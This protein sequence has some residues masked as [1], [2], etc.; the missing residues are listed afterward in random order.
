MI[1]VVEDYL[2][3]LLENK[4][5]YLRKNPDQYRKVLGSSD[6]RVNRLVE[7][8]DKNSI[9][10]IKGYPR[11]P[12]QLPC[13][14]ILLSGEEENQEALGNTDEYFEDRGVMDTR[15]YVENVP[16]K[17]KATAN[18]MLF[19]ELDSSVD[20]IMS[21]S[22]KDPYGNIL[23]L[24]SGDFFINPDYPHQVQVCT[25]IPLEVGDEVYLTYYFKGTDDISYTRYL[26]EANYRLE[27]WANNGDLVVDI[28]HLVK[29]ALLS[30]RDFLGKEHNLFQQR[31]SG[32]D[33]QPA[34]SFFPEF[35]Y[36][37]AISFWCQFSA[38][39]IDS[40]GAEEAERITGFE[41]TQHLY[42]I[43]GT[44]KHG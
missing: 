2:S 8:L 26:F 11:E 3:E 34:P 9:K 31:V 21:V 36:R 1:P 20:I 12:A 28:Y 39:A 33:F 10:I 42:E 5:A 37:R 13:I 30:G 6:L 17:L 44:D 29:W 32:A 15:N 4:L 18:G 35:V 24:P 38:L 7:Y 23:Q 41:V 16:H 40:L 25:M 14:C 43:E 22:Y 27:S 19:A